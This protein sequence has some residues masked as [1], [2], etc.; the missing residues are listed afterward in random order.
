[1]ILFVGD[2]DDSVR[3]RAVEYDPS[4]FLIDS[5]NLDRVMKSNMVDLVA[6]TSFADLPKITETRNV[7]LELLDLAEEIYYISP[8]RWSDHTDAFDHWSNQRITEYFLSEIDRKKKNVHGLELPSWKNNQYLSLVDKRRGNTR[9]LWVSGCSIA[10]GSGVKPQEKFGSLLAGKLDMPASF[11]TKGGSGIPWAA[12]QIL[13]SDMRSGD[14][15]VWGV[16]S[17]Y[18]FCVWDRKLYQYN[19]YNFKASEDRSI[20]TNL[21]NMVYRAVT[22]IHQVS[23]FCQK[24]N[25]LLILL[26]IISSETIRLIFHDCPDW[27]DPGYQIG[28]IDYGT[29]KIHPGPK[30]HSLWADFCYNII[31][32]DQS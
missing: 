25:V 10:H 32:K 31:V 24:S 11:L 18:R 21:E 4:A 19:P 16:T 27:Y 12:D 17:E 6:Y 3:N 5:S 7:F 15:L 8:S 2:V 23:N 1:M 30:Q 20:S 26:P 28:S 29:D 14:I 9:Q 13:R 22:S